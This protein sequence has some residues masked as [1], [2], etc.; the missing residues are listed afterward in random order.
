[1]EQNG[2]F[3][4]YS[5]NRR[6]IEGIDDFQQALEQEYL[7]QAT[8]K[9][10]PSCSEGGEFWLQLL[11]TLPIRAFVLELIHDAAKDGIIYMGKKYVLSPLKN[12]LSTLWKKNKDTWELKILKTSFKF[13]D[14]EVVFGALRE[15]ELEN[16]EAILKMV[17]AVKQELDPEDG[18]PIIRIELPAEF[19]PASR[20]FKL[21][22]WRVDVPNLLDS[23]WIITYEDNQKT[24]YDGKL[25]R[26]LQISDFI[27]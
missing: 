12:A 26:E 23:V 2:I 6:E 17:Y 9:W 16:I 1:M 18:F 22:S 25:G 27:G 21:D 19:I 10:V 3:V 8:P 14:L 11:L 7:C 5:Y 13:N 4:S 15:D 24:L 20:E